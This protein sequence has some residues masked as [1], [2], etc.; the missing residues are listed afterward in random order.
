ME[1]ISVGRQ[2]VPLN[3]QT[4]KILFRIAAESFIK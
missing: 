3:K 1:F 4:N 2:E